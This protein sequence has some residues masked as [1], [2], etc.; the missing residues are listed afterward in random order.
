MPRNKNQSEQLSFSQLLA[1]YTVQIPIIQRDYAQGRESKTSLRASFLFAIRDGIQ[2]A[3]IELDFVY[4]DLTG[5]IFQP[6]DGQQ[7]L[8]TLYLLYWYA[9]IRD[10]VDFS[11]YQFL[12]NFTY[13]TRMS[14]RDFCK[15][16][17]NSQMEITKGQLPSVVIKDAI[18]YSLSWDRDPTVTGMLKTLDH[19]SEVF[20]GVD[21]LWTELIKLE[22]PPITFH[23]VVL[24]DFGLSDDLYIKMNARGK[25][26]TSFENFK[27]VFERK[28]GK[29]QWDK[30]RRREEHFDIL[31]DT[32]WTHLF[33]TEFEPRQFDDAILKFIANSLVFSL[34]VS[35]GK[36]SE[37]IRSL[38]EHF[39]NTNVDDFNKDDYEDLYKSL[40]CFS[41]VKENDLDVNFCWHR[42][43]QNNASLLKLVGGKTPVTFA[44]RLLFF[45]QTLFLL[46]AGPTFEG[47]RYLDWMRVVRNIVRNANLDNYDAFLGAVSLIKEISQGCQNIYK[48]LSTAQVK[49]GFSRDQV[50]EEVQKATLILADQDGS[51]KQALHSLEDTYFCE[52]SLALPLRYAENNITGE[53]DIKLLKE[54]KRVIEKYFDSGIT[55]EMR[56][57]L[58]TIGDGNYF[59]YWSSW[60][61]ATDCPKY[62][63]IED[64][65]DMRR[66]LK[67]DHLAGYFVI[68]FKQLL[69]KTPA[70]IIDD[71]DP[72]EGSSSWRTLLI[73]EPQLLSKARKKYLAFADDWE[74]CYLI[75][76]SKVAGGE[77]GRNR[78]F[79]VVS[80]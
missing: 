45:A 77:V 30:N 60:L 40:Q 31:V 20:G 29:E 54:A 16:L 73:C 57:V 79:K 6:L 8:T 26:L 27:A 14:S 39:Y 69:E 15:Y 48:F 61:Y 53:I 64:M 7:R 56:S 37:K 74:Y 44:Q 43:L 21:D 35:G 80:V 12:S 32:S 42:L 2:D 9:A 67:S 66:F 71:Y 34:A 22:K 52:G 3:P 33:W 63:L 17:I 46:T 76:G 28:I 70:Q 19:I 24:D 62:R 1:K 68:L 38:L 78:L 25:A 58:L 10:Q 72:S 4:G 75:P 23:C 11:E 49:S 36:E 5:K 13:K 50:N 47:E 59:R 41:K 65:D 55:D 51:L 18:W